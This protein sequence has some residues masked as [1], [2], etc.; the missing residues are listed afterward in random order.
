[1][2][3]RLIFPISIVLVITA[4]FLIVSIF[5]LYTEAEKVQ[6][7]IFATEVLSAGDVVVDEIDELLNGEVIALDIEPQLPVVNIKN[8]SLPEVYNRYSRKFYIDSI[9]AKP[10]GIIRNTT[11]FRGLNILSTYAD[12]FLF[13][14][15]FRHTFPYLPE[16]W[17]ENFDIKQFEDKTAPGKKNRFKK[18]INLLEMDSSTIL[19]ISRTKIDTLL[20]EA[21]GTRIRGHK[22]DF[23]IYNGFT[24][25]FVIEPKFTLPDNILSS[26]FVFSLKPNDR[27]LAPHYL[28]L[29]FPQ[30]RT[31]YFDMMSTIA[32]LIISLLAVILIIAGFTLYHLYRQ[33][34]N[35]DVRDDFV[36]NM[37]HE[38]KTPIATISLAC[39]AI[40]DESIRDNRDLQR[41]YVEIIRDENERLKNMVAN[42]LQLAQMKKGQLKMNF[43]KHDM[44][45]LIHSIADSVSLQINSNNGCLILKLEAENSLLFADHDH[46]E[47][48]IYNLVDNAIKYSNGSPYIEIGTYNDKKN[49]VFYVKDKGIGIAKHHTKRIFRE[50]YRIS[51]GNVHNNKGFGLGLDYVKKIV[52][53]HNGDINVESEL[54]KG[55][56]FTVS[57]PIK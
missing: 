24:T 54:N 13:D 50:F 9:S 48:A 22:F 12:T 36:N 52:S 43:E 55:T 5:R 20:K 29:Y 18:D 47:N 39:E 10:V 53:L 30:E 40:S 42:I 33:K 25:Q 34:K 45:T 44:H 11:T 56:I 37:T 38:F 23:A 3:K 32:I 35:T 2:R 49:F 15:S 1:M 16:R 28:I 14:I 4:G 21:L 31:I 7:S 26:E 51:K 6:K 8:D 19:L 41:S 46:I 27:F 57:L 17:E